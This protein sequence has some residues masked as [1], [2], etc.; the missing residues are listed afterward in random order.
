MHTCRTMNK[1]QNKSRKNKIDL[2]VRS[3]ILIYAMKVPAKERSFILIYLSNKLSHY[4]STLQRN[5]YRTRKYEGSIYM[6]QLPIQT[7]ENGRL[8]KRKQGIIQIINKYKYLYLLILPGLFL[9]I[10]FSYVPMYGIQLAFKD[11]MYNKGIWGSPW[12][13]FKH[14]RFLFKNPEFKL[15]L[16]NT[17]WISLNHLIWGFPAPL[18]LALLLNELKNKNF[19]RVT[20]TILYLPHFISWI[21]MAG[22]I[23]NLFST[24][25]GA[26]NKVL[27]SWDL[28][29]V[30]IMGN[31][32]VFRPML[33]ISSIWKGAGWGTIIYMA[34]ISG[35]DQELYESAVIDGANRFEQCVYI[36][37]PSLRPTIVILLI[38]GVGGLMNSNF[39]Q[40]FN[41]ISPTTRPVGEVIDTYVYKMG[42]VNARYD[43]TTAVGLFKQVINCALLF[44]TNWIVKMLGEEGFI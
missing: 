21:I 39:D 28:S 22:I 16:K 5:N 38:L 33:Y 41:L 4:V 3:D 37:L 7:V 44:L 14:F 43:F 13:G 15:V 26:I 8:V 18:I 6:S 42:I 17:I 31:P 34:G 36:T 30:V 23:F 24:T 29:P 27:V 1:K 10:L 40:I 12:V 2:Q 20:Q 19:K 35:I 32:T 11:F 25:T 9:T